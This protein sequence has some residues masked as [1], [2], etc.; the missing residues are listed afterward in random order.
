MQTDLQNAQAQR[1]LADQEL[2]KVRDEVE[3]IARSL[4]NEPETSPQAVEK[5]A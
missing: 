4:L 2:H 3:R 1:A 5:A